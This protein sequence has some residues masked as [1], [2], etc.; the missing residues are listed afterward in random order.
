MNEIYKI[1]IT[2]NQLR[3]IPTDDRNLLLLASHAVNQLSTLRKVM[4]F[5][6]NY[7]FENPLENT[8]SAGQSHILLRFF[9]GAMAESWEM[10]KRPIN[11]KLIAKDYHDDLGDRGKEVYDRLKKHFSRSNLLHNLRNKIVYHYPEAPELQAAFEDVPEDEDWAWYPSDTINNSFYLASDFVISSG[12][13]RLTGETD[14][15]KAFEKIMGIVVPVSDDLIDLFL[16]LMRAIISRHL[17]E[18]M[19]VPAPG[20]GTKIENAPDLYSV[21]IPFFTTRSDDPSK[22]A[23]V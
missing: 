6:L 17:G 1:P 11:Q 12:I 22:S 13:L 5:S 4:I 18:A 21:A 19:V 8:L 16:F 20:S 7:E 23:S 9:F 10:V 14:T 15:Q 3:A 2:K